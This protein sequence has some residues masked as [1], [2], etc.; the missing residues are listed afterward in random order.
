VPVHVVLDW[1]G[2]VQM[3]DDVL[4]QMEEAGARVERY[5]PL[6]WYHLSR[7][8]H[9]THRK[10]LVVDGRVGFTGGVGIADQ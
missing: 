3:D 6:R 8:N 5:R 10:I 4:V 7:L 1:A 9:R 2:S